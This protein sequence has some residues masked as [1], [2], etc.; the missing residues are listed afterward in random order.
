MAAGPVAQ[1]GGGFFPIEF[2]VWIELSKLILST[3]VVKS[4]ALPRIRIGREECLE[5]QIRR[6]AL[7]DG[8]LVIELRWLLQWRHSAPVEIAIMWGYGLGRCM[9]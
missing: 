5:S 6:N 1:N 4:T 9:A 8:L 3:H 7:V 2:P